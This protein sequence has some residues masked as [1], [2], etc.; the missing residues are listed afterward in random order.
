M[1]HNGQSTALLQREDGTPE[2]LRDGQD[3]DGWH[4]TN[5]GSDWITLKLDEVEVRVEMYRK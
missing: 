3:I 2:W 4:V 5:I 1:L